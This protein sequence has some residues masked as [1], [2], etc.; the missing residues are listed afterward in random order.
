[1]H[2]S[3]V[4]VIYFELYWSKLIYD[5]HVEVLRRAQRLDKLLKDSNMLHAY[6]LVIAICASIF[7]S[8]CTS[9][10]ELLE[11]RIVRLENALKTCKWAGSGKRSGW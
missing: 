3:C 6:V 1:M 2:V 9:T 7:T 10:A 8:G 5:E 11:E 4:F